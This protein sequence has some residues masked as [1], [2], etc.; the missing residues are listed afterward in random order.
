ML[1]LLIENIQQRVEMAK[2]WIQSAIK[3]KGALSKTLGFPENKNIPMSKIKEAEKSNNLTT[4][5]RAV[6]AET[7]KKINNKK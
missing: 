4:R 2:K 3:N 7:L 1:K 6:L 5:K